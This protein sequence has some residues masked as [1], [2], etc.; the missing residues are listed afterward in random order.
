MTEVPTSGIRSTT[1]YNYFS[2]SKTENQKNLEKR[3]I[4]L[5]MQPSDC[6]VVPNLLVTQPNYKILE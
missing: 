1:K 3:T 2:L 4:G 5:E 6:N